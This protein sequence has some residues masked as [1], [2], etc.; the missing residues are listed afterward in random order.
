M[1][2]ENRIPLVDKM[3]RIDAILDEYETNCGLNKF[4]EE[5]QHENEALKLLSMS[6]N[7]MERLSIESCA[8]SALLLGLL[9]FHVQ[10]CI[11]REQSRL[12][13][14]K[15]SIRE[16]ICRKAHQY[17]GAWSNQDM[18]AILD[19]DVARK[20]HEIEKYCQQRID[21]LTYLSSSLK[22]ISELFRNLQMAKVNS[23]G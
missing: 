16:I 14:A 6:R 9:S 12:N 11:N 3:H 4:A 23:N 18:Q 5:F 8:E 2:Q 13:W 7:D 19:N 17:S 10:R 1:D 20:L 15:T 21:R 22:S